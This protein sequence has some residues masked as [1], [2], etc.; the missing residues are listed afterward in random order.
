MNSHEMEEQMKL[1]KL[2]ESDQNEKQRAKALKARKPDTL[3]APDEP[4]E[5]CTEE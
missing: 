1:H 4:I 2:M 5:N 3:P